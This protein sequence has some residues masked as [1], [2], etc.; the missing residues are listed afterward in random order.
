MEKIYENY[1]ITKDGKVF[2]NK[3]QLSTYKGD[4]Y[5][6]IVLQIDGKPTAKYIHRLVA[7]T[8]IDNPKNKATVNHKD[9]NK[10]NNDYTNL[11][12]A[13]QSENNYHS[14][15]MGLQVPY[16]RTGT[17]NPNYKHGKRMQ[18]I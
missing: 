13:T 2:N 6:R 12:W 5:E 4:R 18:V 14:F 3:K 7:E 16:D 11:E 8:F 9:G 10:M 17:N 15:E 1:F